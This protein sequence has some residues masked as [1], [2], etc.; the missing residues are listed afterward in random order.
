MER[1]QTRVKLFF[2]EVLSLNNIFPNGLRAT[3]AKKTFFNNYFFKQL[4]F[5]VVQNC[6][7]RSF[8]W[9]NLFSGAVGGL[10]NLSACE[11]GFE[12]VPLFSS[13]VKS[14]RIYFI[15][16]NTDHWLSSLP[17]LSVVKIFFERK[18][19]RKIV[20]VLPFRGENTFFHH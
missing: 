5:L 19:P 18:S 15:M 12:Y 13:V 6:F 20:F 1:G 2:V 11:C 17:V 3:L 9:E 10:E 16:V 8:S 7:A 4:D 14:Q